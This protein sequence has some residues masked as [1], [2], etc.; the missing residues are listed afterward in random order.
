MG[1]ELMDEVPKVGYQ[2][3]HDYAWEKLRTLVPDRGDRRMLAGM[4][5]EHCFRFNV[6]YIDKVW[7][8]WIKKTPLPPHRHAHS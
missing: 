6:K 1:D 8:K 2:V 4:F 3:A 5:G 7:V